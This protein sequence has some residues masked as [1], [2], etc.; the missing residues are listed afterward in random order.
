MPA[1]IVC[2]HCKQ[3]LRLP[4]WLYD[5]PAECP[6]C[7]GAFAVRWRRPPDEDVVDVLP[8]SDVANVQR[9]PCPRCGQPIRQE[10]A[11]CPFCRRWLNAPDR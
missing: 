4:E 7:R 2:P 11:K 9:R 1:R 5:G 10:A 8:A 3:P 6:Q